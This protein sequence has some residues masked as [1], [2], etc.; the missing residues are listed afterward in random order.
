M[1]SYATNSSGE[2]VDIDE[3]IN[4]AGDDVCS[5]M[6]EAAAADSEADSESG[7][8]GSTR[9]RRQMLLLTKTSEAMS[10]DRALQST[11]SSV[12]SVRPLFSTLFQL[13]VT[14]DAPI[15]ATTARGQ[16]AVDRVAAAVA[17]AMTSSQS[18]TGSSPFSLASSTWTRVSN[19]TS[20]AAWSS[21]SFFTVDS[22]QQY[23]SVP[24]A[25]VPPSNT[26]KWWPVAVGGA[27]SALLLGSVFVFL[28]TRRR[29]AMP[30]EALAAIERHGAMPADSSSTGSA[31]P[32][33]STGAAI[34]PAQAAAEAA[35][36]SPAYHH[37]VSV[38]LEP[39]SEAAFAAASPTTAAAPLSA[40]VP[41]AAVLDREPEAAAA[42]KTT[43]T[44]KQPFLPV[45]LLSPSD[46][47]ASQTGSHQT[48]AAQ[49]DRSRARDV[50]SLPGVQLVT[51][52][53]A[54]R[55]TSPRA[56]SGTAA[57]VASGGESDDPVA[58]ARSL[59]AASDD[60]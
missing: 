21:L 5:A 16:N 17:A 25:A 37:D 32:G 14:S 9:R 39:A 43:V 44:G 53:T 19:L 27:V 20:A 48:L 30:A 34:V 7:A 23:N 46:S 4:D 12:T 36:A 2:D 55:A 59:M 24:G 35:L 51:A 33:A 38:K 60:E 10:M 15:V 29:H 58:T 6:M 56:A 18:S 8:S 49:I 3:D 41:A 40:V 22:V 50:Q 26:N 31:A 45:M 52:A 28:L 47:E 42:V 11:G 1:V 57:N 54:P 13:I